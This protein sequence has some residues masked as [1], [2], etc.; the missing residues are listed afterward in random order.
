MF[1]LLTD[2]SSKHFISFWKTSVEATP[3]DF[4]FQSTLI[5]TFLFPF[6]QRILSET[7]VLSS[8]HRKGEKLLFKFIRN[9]FQTLHE[10]G[11]LL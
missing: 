2:I 3:R 8:F 4:F 11:F 1:D 7:F 10:I 9:P 6:K 5:L